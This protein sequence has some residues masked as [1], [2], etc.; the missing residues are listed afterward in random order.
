[1]I[2]YADQTRR[3]D[4]EIVDEAVAYF[5]AGGPSRRRSRTLRRRMKRSRLAPLQWGLIGVT[6]AIIA[7]AIAFTALHPDVV[8][9]VYDTAT[10]SLLSMASSIARSARDLLQL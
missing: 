6:T 7:G 8:L 2:G 9:H 1:M 3:I 5:E 4:R 10:S